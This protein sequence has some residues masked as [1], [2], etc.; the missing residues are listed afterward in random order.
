MTLSGL[1]LPTPA[2]C[3]LDL[4]TGCGIQ[5]MHASRFADRIVATDI[6]ERALEIARLNL[7]LNGIDGVELRLGSLSS[8]PLRA[9]GS[10]AS[11]R[12]RRSSSPRASRACPSTTTAT[13]AW[14]VTPS[15]KR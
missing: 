3:V 9:S 4:G 6:S 1:M 14:W 15:S 13:A 7:V 10:T 12:I 2:R 8:S 11:S 5:A